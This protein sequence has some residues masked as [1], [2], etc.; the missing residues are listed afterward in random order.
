MFC[1]LSFLFFSL[2]F[3]S[4]SFAREEVLVDTTKASKMLSEVFV[5]GKSSIKGNSHLV[6]FDGLRLLAA[7]KSELI[8]LSKLDANLANQSFREVF[9]RTPGLHVIESDPSG[10]NTSIAIRGLSTNR[11][12]D[13]NMRQNGYDITPDPM[14]YNEA[15]YTPSFE[16]VEKIEI[17]RGAA[18]L[19]YGPQVG[20]LINYILE[21]PV[22]DKK[23]GG[24]VQQTFG[25][26][27]LKSSLIKLRSG[28]KKIA[29][30]G[31]HQF[32]EGN[33]FR[34][35]SNFNSNQSYFRMDWKPF[36]HGLVTFELTKSIA[37]AQLAGG[38]SEAQFK[39]DPW[40]SYRARNY[41]YSH[42]FMPV[43]KFN[44]SP[45]KLFN[46]QIQIF[47]IQSGRSQLGFTKTN[48]VLD[49]PN[50]AG[51]Y[52]NRSLDRDEYMSYGAEF[53]SGLNAFNEKWQTSVGLRIFRGNMF[54]QQQGIANN[55]S[56]YSENLVDPKFPR[57]L[58]F[59][60]QN[61]S[62]FIENSLAITPKFKLAGGLRYEYILSQ[63]NGNLDINTNFSS[64][65]R[66]R[67]F[68]LWG[69]GASFKPSP[70]L[71]IYSNASQSFRPISFS[72]LLP[73]ST[74]DIVDAALKDARSLNFDLGIRGKKGNFLRYDI[75]A[76]H[77]EFSD[78]IGNLSMKN[79]T[80]QSYLYRTNL[81]LS[82]SK[83]VELYAEIDPIS[84]L[85]GSSR[86][87]QISVFLSAGLN[88]SVYEN[89][90]LI[91]GENLA[92]KRLENAPQQIIRS[93]LTYTHKRLSFTYQ[94]SYTAESFSDAQNTVKPNPAGTIG[95]IP[96]YTLDDFS[97]TYKYRKH[98][99]LKGSVNNVMNV[100][101]LTRR[102]TGAF[103][104][105][106]ILPGAPRNVSCTLGFTF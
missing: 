96:G 33:G 4:I 61:F 3:S 57:S 68:I 9:G 40:V 59:V 51:N 50:S 13:F 47:A 80:G 67:S 100:S 71:E 69:V 30:L 55:G 21:K 15:Y 99:L 11:S 8:V 22:F 6:D 7:K 62:A 25:S 103:P 64:P 97:F 89:F 60:N 10:F 41:Y 35:N 76:Y 74:T 24:E 49:V 26:F 18:A 72:D 83:G 92:G 56:T 91:S 58:N 106:G 16:W 43:V 20:G 85:H 52:A 105:Y 84:F 48:D 32:R 2:F 63:G 37:Q 98:W 90:P 70:E 31:S 45:S 39:S 54:R 12:W 66:L 77:L 27:G 36:T 14:G 88:N 46:S 104:G 95:L 86:Y 82:S 65:D 19:Q 5:L 94:I 42:W 1:R 78:R 34:P 101:Y 29:F 75:S 73:S 87:G 53:R 93:G 23:F 79:S 81:G 17:V 38:I 102:G 28:M 44:Y